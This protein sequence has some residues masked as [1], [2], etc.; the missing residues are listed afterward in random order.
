MGTDERPPGAETPAVGRRRFVQ[1]LAGE[2][3]GHAGRLAGMSQ[4]VHSSMVA[5]G[6]AF[7]EGMESI[8]EADAAT[9]KQA[10]AI[11]PTEPVP[12][13][14]AS[15]PRVAEIT[16]EI[17]QI[18]ERAETAVMA[19]NQ[20]GA[21]PQLS[22]SRLSFDGEA[23]RIPSRQMTARVANL[24]R[25]PQVTLAI[26]DSQTGDALVV[27]GRAELVY[28]EEAGPVETSGTIVPGDSPVMIVLRPERITR[29]S[30]EGSR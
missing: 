14:P 9:P 27:A 19:A 17:R 8:S 20:P 4:V 2:A 11:R 25:D 10:R 18:L 12:P 28:G 26:L 21:A 16:P 13:A 6:R 5:A 22:V 1:Q 7:S 24:Q 15:S 29:R 3:V 23:L 30:A